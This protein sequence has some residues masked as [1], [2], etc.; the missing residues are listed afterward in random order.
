MSLPFEAWT[1]APDLCVHM[2]LGLLIPGMV[3][4]VSFLLL[5]AYAAYNPVSKQYL[6]RVSFR[7]LIYALTAHV[8][9]GIA[10]TIGAVQDNPGWRCDVISF[11][12]NSSLTFS[13]GMFFCM[14]LNLP[15]VLAYN[16]NG[17]RME[18]FYVAVTAVIC[19]V[20]NIVPYAAGNTEW[21]SMGSTCEYGSIDTI[22][23]LRWLLTT[24]TVWI[25]LA[26][27][28]EL[29]AFLIIVGYLLAYALDQRHLHL[30]PPG[31]D[32]ISSAAS[33]RPG[34]RIF[35]F[36]NIILRVGLYPLVSCLLN[37]STAVLDLYQMKHHEHSNLSWRLNL[38]DLAIFAGRP[39]IYGLLAA[40]DPSFLRALH[41]LR[42]P[43]GESRLQGEASS[44]ERPRRAV[45][46]QAQTQSGCLTTVID[47][48]EEDEEESIQGVLEED[49][50]VDMEVL[51]KHDEGQQEIA[52]EKD[53]VEV[54]RGLGLS[55]SLGGMDGG[56]GRREAMTTRG[57]SAL[58]AQR[59]TRV[60][61]LS[62]SS[63]SSIDFVSF[64]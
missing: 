30:N 8:L 9:F 58:E 45:A 61:D 56:P 1:P 62:A 17:R 27:V 19:I 33:Q 29:V 3:L 63:R 20:L 28:G 16:V 31:A 32:S 21:T 47:L 59:E 12:A 39:L 50:A 54:R 64:I 13:A 53:V 43:D 49:I 5:C 51:P 22:R 26:S 42:Y 52:K 10:F 38:T 55:L 44:H 40:T 34:S 25:V 2:I 11:V 37:I 23:M 18:K 4:T 48:R 24:Q 46:A 6:D 36:R 14:A 41:A 60:A 15:L 7:L 57:L 35:R